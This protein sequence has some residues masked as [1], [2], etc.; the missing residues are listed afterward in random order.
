MIQQLYG[1]QPPISKTIQKRRTRL[2]EKQG[3]SNGKASPSHGRAIVT[4]A[5]C[6]HKMQSGKPVRRDG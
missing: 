4:P 6:R 5:F 1:H 2:L 3:Q